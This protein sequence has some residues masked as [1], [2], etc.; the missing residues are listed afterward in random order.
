MNNAI[1]ATN[2]IA[3]AFADADPDNADAYMERAADYVA[4]LEELKA[5]IESEVGTLSD[6]QRKLV[7]SH[8][9]FQY[10]AQ[11][12]GFEVV[13]TAFGAGTTEGGDPSAQEIAELV[14]L[15]Q[16]ENVPA[17]FAENVT[18]PDLI[19]VLA[20][21]AGATFAP[22]LYTDALGEEGSEG[23]TYIG[24]MEFNATTIVSALSDEG[25]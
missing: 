19:Q 12:Y 2:T 11:A 1:V 24:M 9:S 6:E 13:G 22:P 15:I 23:D 25:E 17:I 21:E 4:E 16:E 3:E 20:D 5:F 8:D 18:N 10:F 14:E 7:T